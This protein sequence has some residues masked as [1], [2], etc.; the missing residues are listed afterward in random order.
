MVLHIKQTNKSVKKF[1]KKTLA[2][3]KIFENVCGEGREEGQ[4]QWVNLLLAN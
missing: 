3:E 2:L 4:R 1:F